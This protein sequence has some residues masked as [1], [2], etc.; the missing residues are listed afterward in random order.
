LE[1]RR[2]KV[3]QLEVPR[4]KILARYIEAAPEELEKA[5]GNKRCAV[6]NTLGVTVW[7]A[8]AKADPI[9]IV[10]GALGG[11]VFCHN[12]ATSRRYIPSANP[13]R[14]KLTLIS[15]DGALKATFTLDHN[16]I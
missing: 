4:E 9:R 11:E 7:A 16:V 10:F 5:D 3:R 13:V 8:R 14:L 2:S 6:Y 15:S 12:D 1:E